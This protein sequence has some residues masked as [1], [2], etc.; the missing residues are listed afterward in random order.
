MIDIIIAKVKGKELD[1]KTV[2]SS[3]LRILSK[4]E[5]YYSLD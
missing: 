4:T 3:F 5:N 1:A 2:Y